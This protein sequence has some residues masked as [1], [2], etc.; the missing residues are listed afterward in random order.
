MAAR[1]EYRIGWD[2]WWSRVRTYEYVFTVGARIFI[3]K[4]D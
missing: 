2:E 4:V 3:Y 1:Y